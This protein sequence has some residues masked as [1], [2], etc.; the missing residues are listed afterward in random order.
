MATKTRRFPFV[1]GIKKF[2]VFTCCN[3]ITCTAS[4][5]Q[6]V[7]PILCISGDSIDLLDN[8]REFVE[9]GFA[10]FISAWNES[11]HYLGST[12]VISD[13]KSEKSGISLGVNDGAELIIE[14]DSGKEL[15]S[16]GEIA[17][18]LREL[19]GTSNCDT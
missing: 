18:G 5:E 10:P 15:I 11:D 9:R 8:V 1:G 14:S 6:K 16:S 7:F 19:V 4:I 13:G 17:F 2:K 12:V 3:S